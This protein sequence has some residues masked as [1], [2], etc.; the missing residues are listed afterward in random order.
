VTRV[1]PPAPARPPRLCLLIAGA[2]LAIF[3]IVVLSAHGMG[4]T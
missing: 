4:V 3:V 1:D 2:A